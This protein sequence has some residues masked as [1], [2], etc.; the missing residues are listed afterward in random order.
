M[1]D[2]DAEEAGAAASLEPRYAEL[3]QRVQPVIAEG[4]RLIN[5]EGADIE[6]LRFE[7]RPAE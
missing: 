5:E 6:A 4:L 7:I 3:V 2:H 1:T